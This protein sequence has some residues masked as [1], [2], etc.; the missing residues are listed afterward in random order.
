MENVV[1]ELFKAV[2]RF[3]AIRP[4]FR[5]HGSLANVEFFI[6]MGISVLSEEKDEGI[7]LGDIIRETDMSM[8]AASK[9]I[10]ILEK[11]G[12]LKRHISN[13]DRRNVYVTLTEQ[14][15]AICEEEKE[16]KHE[17]IEEVIK[18]MGV[19]DVAQ[20][21]CLVNRM[22]DIME[23]MEQETAEELQKGE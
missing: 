1:G 9:K 3:H 23:Q 15:K 20:M 7:T 13:K 10:T 18:R 22:F 19:E 5:K 14:G 8:S 12:L 16:K 17:W 6:L 21:V 2:H 4:K 11:K